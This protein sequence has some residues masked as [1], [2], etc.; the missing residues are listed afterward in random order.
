LSHDH[1]KP[2][3]DIEEEPGT[4]RSN[5][6]CMGAMLLGLLAI[7]NGYSIVPK[8]GTLGALTM[9]AG[10]L[11]L[12]LNAARLFAGA[13]RWASQLT[14]LLGVWSWYSAGLLGISP[15]V[16]EYH[17][18]WLCWLLILTGVGYVYMGTW[19]ALGA[20]G[21]VEWEPFWYKIES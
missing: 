21:R 17:V 20:P 6:A 10:A 18:L 5:W 7:F 2:H 13:G 3:V 12:V 16:F 15:T 8:F 9:A 11:V 1:A 4:Y 19:A 14:I